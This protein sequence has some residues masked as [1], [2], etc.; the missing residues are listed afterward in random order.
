[1]PLDATP[2]DRRALVT[3]ATGTIGSAVARALAK[4]GVWVALH[5]HYQHERAVELAGELQALG[6]DPP[7]V[8]D[9]VAR[10]AAALSGR[11]RRRWAA[12]TSSS[13]GRGLPPQ[14]TAGDE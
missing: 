3:G 1:M 11:R 14:F 4:A 7:L 5:Y 13:T 12:S 2:R 9:D 8:Q 6:Q 10:D